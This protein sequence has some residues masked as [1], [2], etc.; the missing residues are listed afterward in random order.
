MMKLN[1]QGGKLHAGEDILICSYD[2]GDVDTVP[3][4]FPTDSPYWDKAK[5]DFAMKRA[6]YDAREM[7]L[8]PDDP[9]VE[10]PDGTV[11]QID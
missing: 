8:I 10:L 9:A 6:I 1:A 4:P 11:Y 5:W 7:G 2:A 3:F